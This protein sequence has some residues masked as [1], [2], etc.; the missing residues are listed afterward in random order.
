MRARNPPSKQKSAKFYVIQ[1]ARPMFISVRTCARHQISPK[2]THSRSRLLWTHCCCWKWFS[3]RSRNERFWSCI[4]GACKPGHVIELKVTKLSSFFCLLMYFFTT[5]QQLY[6]WARV[7]GLV[8][9]VIK[10]L[11]WFIF[12][13]FHNENEVW[14]YGNIINQIRSEWEDLIPFLYCKTFKLQSIQTII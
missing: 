9:T 3:Q 11:K 4:T 14:W 5:P 6:Y 13:S 12:K 1:R 10:F 7:V 2:H 8:C